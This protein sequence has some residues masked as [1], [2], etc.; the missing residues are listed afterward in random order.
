MPNEAEYTVDQLITTLLADPLDEQMLL[1]LVPELL[2][3]QGCQQPPYHT[4]DA[5]THTLLVVQAVAPVPLL[6]VAAL[7]HDIAK[8]TVQTWD[9]EHA[10]FYGHETVGAALANDILMRLGAGEQFRKN[11]VQIIALH[12]RFN[13]YSHD[14]GSKAVRRLQRDA[15]TFLFQPCILLAIADCSSDKYETKEAAE[16][17]LMDLYNRAY[18][19]PSGYKTH[20]RS[21]AETA[22]SPL[23]GS[24]VRK[25]VPGKEPGPW[26]H[27]V[28]RYLAKEVTAG[29]LDI[30]DVERA[31]ELARD[32]LRKH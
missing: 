3:L 30:T 22:A 23:S 28:K 11:V 4:E 17:R 14:W 7:L 18:A 24:A 5:Y 10:H 27:G 12:M 13:K 29:R 26:I 25:L 2:P 16:T 31:R 32:Y 20:H 21:S 19:I 6:R 1:T 8:P 9:G 15:G